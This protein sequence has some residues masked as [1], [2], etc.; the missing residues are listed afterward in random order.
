V[1]VLIGVVVVLVILI[2][3]VAGMRVAKPRGGPT[4]VARVVDGRVVVTLAL[5]APDGSSPA[6]DRLVDDAAARAFAAVPEA[7]EVEVCDRQ[8]RTLGVRNRASHTL[9]PPLEL[10]SDLL[11]PHLRH[12]HAPLVPED[13]LP[14][15]AHPHFLPKDAP[16]R[17]LADRFDL[18]PRVRAQLADPNDAVALV[19]AL[20]AA[21]G[22]AVERRDTALLLDGHTAVI[23]IPAALGAPVGPDDLNHAYRVFTSMRARDGVVV[24][25]GIMDG[26]EVRR[27]EL[28]APDLRH[29]GPDGIQRMADAVALGADPVALVVP[30]IVRV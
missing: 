20:L 4:S 9:P 30:P 2:A 23:V 27:R 25:P 19:A 1:A 7:R 22:H 17:P 5:D 14:D 18:P 29:A 12:T 24:T 16:A 11:E 15:H 6:L 13:E 10:P 28:L 26:H 21:S 3:L 8:A